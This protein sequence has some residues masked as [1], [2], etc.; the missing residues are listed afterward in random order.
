MGTR[1]KVILQPQ[2]FQAGTV[3]SRVIVIPPRNIVTAIVMRLRSEISA[4]VLSKFRPG[5]AHSLMHAAR[6][7]RGVYKTLKCDIYSL[8]PCSL[9]PPP[10]PPPTPLSPS[11]SRRV[12]SLISRS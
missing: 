3:T 4:K 9:P 6:Y 5:V 10:P 12:C 7:P 1:L 11:L 2:G 8:F